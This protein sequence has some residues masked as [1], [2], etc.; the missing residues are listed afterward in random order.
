MD[1]KLTLKLDKDVI[2]K[3]KAYASA[4][5]QSLS[6]LIE[7]YLRSLVATEQT[8]DDEI[9]IAPFVENLATGVNIPVDLDNKSEYAKHLAKKHK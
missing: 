4:H 7:T 3:A 2:E 8:D 1:T 9:Q 5:N 6:K